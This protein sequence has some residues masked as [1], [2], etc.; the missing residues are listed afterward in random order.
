MENETHGGN[1]PWPPPELLKGEE[2]YKV[3]SILKHRQR[4]RGYQYLI[5]WKGYL[6]NDATWEAKTAFSDDGNML[7]AYKD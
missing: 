7:V 2:V 5:K 4:G 1:F 6:I 3:E